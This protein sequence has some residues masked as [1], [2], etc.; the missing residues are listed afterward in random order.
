MRSLF[1]LRS[2]DYYSPVE[3]VSFSLHFFKLGFQILN[4]HVSWMQILFHALV[5]LKPFEM[6]CEKN[7]K[8][9]R[10]NQCESKR[11]NICG[12]IFCLILSMA[13][14]LGFIV[15]TLPPEHEKR[16]KTL[17]NTSRKLIKQPP[18]SI[19]IGINFLNSW[20]LQCPVYLSVKNHSPVP[21]W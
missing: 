1:I 11:W 9:L 7:K 19:S 8:S 20:T 17:K 14:S 3:L 10:M 2:W 6:P 4:L 13:A 12:L 21:A 18:I 16:F 15:H 5:R